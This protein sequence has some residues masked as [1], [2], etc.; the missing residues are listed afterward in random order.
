MLKDHFLN[1]KKEIAKVLVTFGYVGLIPFFPG[2]LASLLTVLLVVAVNLVLSSTGYGVAI[3][4]FGASLLVSLLVVDWSVAHLFNDSDPKQVVLDEVAGMSL[5]LV[6]VPFDWQ[7]TNGIVY[8]MAFFCFRFFDI[9]KPFP[10][11]FFDNRDGFFFVV[12]DDLVAAVL[13]WPFTFFT[14]QLLSS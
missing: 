13:T 4:F 5:S 12:L 8:I 6:V 11:S 2:T 14:Y 10:V 3:V 9:L 1:F 7:L